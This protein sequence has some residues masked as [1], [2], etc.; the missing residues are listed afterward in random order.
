MGE[1]MGRQVRQLAVLIV[2]LV[3]VLP[4]AKAGEPNAHEIFT[5][6]KIVEVMRR[7]RDYQLAYPW[8]ET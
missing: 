2:C 7:V 8:R 1:L 6:E 5:R 3:S 4:A